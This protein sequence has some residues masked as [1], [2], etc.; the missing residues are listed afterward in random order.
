VEEQKQDPAATPRARLKAWRRERKAHDPDRTAEN[1]ARGWGGR[2]PGAGAP[3]GNLN[4]LK[5]GRYSRYQRAVIEALLQVPETREIMIAISKR[6][7]AQTGR[8]EQGGAALMSELVRKIGILAL[9]GDDHLE[10]IQDFLAAI[11]TAEAQLQKILEKQSRR[12]AQN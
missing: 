11:R 4:A 1:R 9:R 6:Q 10:D 12:P 8:A 7:R 5:H 3:K 2:R